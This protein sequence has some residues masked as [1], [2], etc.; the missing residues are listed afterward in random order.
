M[1]WENLLQSAN[2]S[3]GL[4]DFFL[5]AQNDAVTRDAQQASTDLNR[6]QLTAAQDKLTQS[7]SQEARYQADLAQFLKKPTPQAVSDMMFRY[8]DKAADISKGW[9]PR[10]EADKRSNLGYMGGVYNALS[11]GTPQGRATALTALKQRRA[12]DAAAGLDVTVDDAQIAAIEGGNKDAINATM[13][14]FLANMAAIDPAKFADNYKTVGGSKELKSA[15]PG[16]YVYDQ[17]GQVVFKVPG[18]DF[19]LG[20]GQTRFP[21]GG[22][23][24]SDGAPGAGAYDV[25]LG[26][27]KY[28]SPDKPL[29]SMTLGQVYDFGRK[30]LIPNSKAAGVGKDSRGTIG[31]SAVGAYQITGETMARIAPQVLGAD[32]RNQQFTPQVQD[33]LGEAIFNDA[34]SRGVP[35]NQV[36]ASLTPGQAA[37]MK[38]KSWDQVKGT[39][40]QKESGVSSSV[41]GPAQPIA[42]VPKEQVRPMTPQEKDQWGLPANIS[43]AMGANGQ[44]V[45]IGG[46]STANTRSGE[47]AFRKEFDALPEVKTFKVVRPQIQTIRS[48]ATKPDPTGPD[49]IALI[50]A[51]MKLLDPNSVVREGEFATAQNSQGI[52]DQWRNAYN[53]ALSG[54]RLNPV[55]RKDMLGTANRYYGNY[56]SAYNTAAENYRGYARDAGLK[57]DNVARTYTPDGSPGS[58]YNRDGTPKGDDSSAGSSRDN[59]QPVRSVQEAARYRG[60]WVRTPDGRVGKVR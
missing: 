46:Q 20:Q 50:F 43:Y 41:S 7:K 21:G 36:W 6:F 28:G 40:A 38:G 60:K 30:T 29:T 55:Q 42:S 9:A 44:P 4:A 24:T 39:I 15:G 11:L 3:N 56:R 34:V 18:P 49:D 54:A 10:D 37:G 2:Q 33:K 17:Q 59:P 57:P 12:A 47:G 16:D 45:P 19:T 27:G 23:P 51:F 53:R 25:V 52:P 8:P 26:N 32:W 14:T 48:L 35:L 1:A 5:K 13:G 31:S 58:M 22:G